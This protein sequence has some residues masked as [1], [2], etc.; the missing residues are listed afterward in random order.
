MYFPSTSCFFKLSLEKSLIAI[1]YNKK[2]V[3]NFNF[4]LIFFL[5]KSSYYKNVYY[6][7]MTEKNVW[8]F[9]GQI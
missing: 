4:S 1:L 6:K 9:A 8:Q 3:S 5:A 7:K 2:S